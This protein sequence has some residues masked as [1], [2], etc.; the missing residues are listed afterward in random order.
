ML[1]QQDIEAKPINEN[2]QQLVGAIAGKVPERLLIDDPRK[3]RMK[4]IDKT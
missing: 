3:G 1:A 4:K 2:I